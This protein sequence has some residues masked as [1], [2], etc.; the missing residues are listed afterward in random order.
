M[1]VCRVQLL[2]SDSTNQFS[3]ARQY[4]YSFQ[5]DVVDAQNKLQRSLM[6]AYQIMQICRQVRIPG[7]AVGHDEP[8]LTSMVDS[9][10]NQIL[11][12]QIIRINYSAIETTAF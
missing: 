4:G 8:S 10:T 6:N 12:R 11:N 7:Y 9:S 1:P 5:I 3:N 2:S